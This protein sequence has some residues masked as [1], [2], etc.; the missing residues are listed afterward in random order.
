ML[1]EL[2]A[3][4]SIILVSCMISILYEYVMAALAVA[5]SKSYAGNCKR[6]QWVIVTDAEEILTLVS[7]RRLE[8]D[9][10]DWKVPWLIRYTCGNKVG[11]I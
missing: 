7:A 11:K 8:K 10:C 3:T 9:N 4:L 5:H 2:K 6:E 1:D